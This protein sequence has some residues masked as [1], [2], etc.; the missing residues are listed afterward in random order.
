MYDLNERDKSTLRKFKFN[1]K[2]FLKLKKKKKSHDQPTKNFS[3]ENEGNY[4]QFWEST[5]GK[6]SIRNISKHIQK[7]Q[8]EITRER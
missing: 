1:I 4:S 2:A 3:R 5:L 6:S 7:T 8:D